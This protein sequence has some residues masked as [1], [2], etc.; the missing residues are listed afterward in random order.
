MSAPATGAAAVSV[1]VASTGGA[2]SSALLQAAMS[3]VEASEAT[4]TAA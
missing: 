4:A 2:A 1:A 3:R